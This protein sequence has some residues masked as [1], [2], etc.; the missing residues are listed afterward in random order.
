MK[1]GKW[2]LGYYGFLF[3]AFGIAGLMIPDQ[4]IS[5]IHYGL[6]SPVAKMEFM[7]TYGGLFTGLG[8]FMIYCIKQHVQ[9]GLV[10]VLFTMGAM[11][12]T[13][14]IGY[15]SFG[16]ANIFQYIYLAGE[17]FTVFLVGFILVKFNHELTA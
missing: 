6:N 4:V 1:I 14:L 16:E 2:V 11:L 7:A 5:L 8:A 12:F 15:F 9:V 13:R 17:L 10:S 3:V